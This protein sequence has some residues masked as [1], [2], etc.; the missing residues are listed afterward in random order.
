MRKAAH[1]ITATC[2]MA[3][4]AV[5]S[6]PADA[7]IVRTFGLDAMAV[8]AQAIVRGQVVGA[9]VVWDGAWGNVYTHTFVRVDEVLAGSDVVGGVIAVRQIGGV[10][11]GIETRV[12]GTAELPLDAEVVIF[13]RTD[14]AYHYLVGMAQG[15]Y[16]VRRAAAGAARVG[17]RL[18]GVTLLDPPGPAR[19]TAPDRL[20]LDELR[21]RVKA[22]LATTGE[23]R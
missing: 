20:L 6:G 23:D 17:R 19:A 16:E 22:A 18:A 21:A 14:G 13:A 4:L 8:E 10:L 9:E 7:T 15:C 11:D 12:V 5:V 1:A 2:A 3:A